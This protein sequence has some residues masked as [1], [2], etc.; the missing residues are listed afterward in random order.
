MPLSKSTQIAIIALVTI[1]LIS[2]AAL[3]L[4]PARD[5]DPFNSSSSPKSLPGPQDLTDKSFPSIQNS[6]TLFVLDFYYPGCGPCQFMNKTTSELSDELGGQVQFG[7]MNA[8]SS[9]NKNTVRDYKISAF[10][11]LLFF[12]EGFWLAG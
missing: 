5:S 6:S 8:R 2:A 4:I 12:Q 3:R 1:L 10:P 9:E 11:T 7:R